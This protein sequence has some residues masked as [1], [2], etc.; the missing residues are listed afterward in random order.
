MRLGNY[1]CQLASGSLAQKAYGVAEIRERHRHRYEFNNAHRSALEKAG[2]RVSGTYPKGDLVEVIE[3]P[4]HPWF[5]ACQF[6]PEFTSNP[7]VGHPLFIAFVKA[8][9]AQQNPAKKLTA[10]EVAA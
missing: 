3:I 2:L 4:G 1:T 7:R 5:V 9:L 6:H 8:A 10:K